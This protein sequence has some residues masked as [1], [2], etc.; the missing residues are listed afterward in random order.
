MDPENKHEVC[1][2]RFIGSDRSVDVYRLWRAKMLQLLQMNRE[3]WREESVNPWSILYKVRSVILS[4]NHAM[5]LSANFGDDCAYHMIYS[6]FRPDMQNICL[7]PK[8]LFVS[9]VTSVPMHMCLFCRSSLGC[10][11]IVSDS[12][13]RSTIADLD[14]KGNGQEQ[15]IAMNR[16]PC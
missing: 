10:N 13:A 3:I 5:E 12:L 16:A 9:S 2:L 15:F 4:N 11:C 14:C 7:Q 1:W 8:S 6:L